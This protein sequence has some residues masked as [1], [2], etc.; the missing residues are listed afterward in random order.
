MARVTPG[1]CQNS[2]SQYETSLG[3]EPGPDAVVGLLTRSALLHRLELHE[4]LEQVE[5]GIE[6]GPDAVV[7]CSTLGAQFSASH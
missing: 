1:S 5:T 4:K 6:P 3:I 7:S 2:T